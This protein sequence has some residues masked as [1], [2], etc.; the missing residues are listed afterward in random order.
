MCRWDQLGHHCVVEDRC[1]LDRQCSNRKG[2]KGNHDAMW[3]AR[4]GVPKGPATQEKGDRK[5]EDPNLSAAGCI[6]NGAKDWGQQRNSQPCRSGGIS[7]KALALRGIVGQCGRKIGCKYKGGNEGEKGLC[8][9]VKET[10][11]YDCAPPGL[12]NAVSDAAVIRYLLSW[13]L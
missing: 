2:K 12:T 9:P 6:G 11:G 4:S 8:G 10:P 5:A 3:I 13:D 1:D 7:P